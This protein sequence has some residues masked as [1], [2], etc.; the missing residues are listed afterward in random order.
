MGL[1]S[2]RQGLQFPIGSGKDGL[3]GTAGAN[4]N[5]DAP[6]T[7]EYPC[8]ELEQFSTDGSHLCLGQLGRGQ[9]TLPQII[10][11]HIG[12]RGKPQPQLITHR[13]YEG[14][15]RSRSQFELLFLESVF[16]LASGTVLLDI[17]LAGRKTLPLAGR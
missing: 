6:H 14:S 4:S 2:I 15:V 17:E 9:T 3:E 8:P 13:K 5:L 16:H 12:Q 1:T 7:D 10:H 11:Q